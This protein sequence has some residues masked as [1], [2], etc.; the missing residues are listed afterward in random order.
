MTLDLFVLDPQTL[1]ITGR[2]RLDDPVAEKQDGHYANCY[3]DNTGATPML[4]VVDYE[5]CPTPANPTIV[6]KP[7]IVQYSFAVEELLA[8]YKEETGHDF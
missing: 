7:D 2:F 6:R 4:R 8:Q 5:T 1:E 3:L